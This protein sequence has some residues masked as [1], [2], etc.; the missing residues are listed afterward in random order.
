VIQAV[1]CVV[2]GKPTKQFKSSGRYSAYCSAKHRDLHSRRKEATCLECGVVFTHY[3]PAS[4]QHCSISCAQRARHRKARSARQQPV[5]RNCGRGFTPKKEKYST[6]CS[7]ECAFRHKASNAAYKWMSKHIITLHRRIKVCVECGR[8]FY[9]R[10]KAKACSSECYK[11]IARRTQREKYFV[12][13]AYRNEPVSKNCDWCGTLYVAVTHV[14]RRR[15]CSKACCNAKA[16]RRANKLRRARMANNGPHESFDPEAIFE[17]DGYT[18]Y[19]CGVQTDNSSWPNPRYPTIDHVIP[20][21]M[22]GTHTMAN[23]R[24]ACFACN[25]IKSDTLPV[26]GV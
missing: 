15:F 12:P 6:F 24:C 13:A 2:C 11:A 14:K 1:G 18:C 3:G 7:R 17:R 25:S 5:C 23:V 16:K 4:Q 8:R 26:G 21:A 10:Y 19:L 22:G 9:S 20:L